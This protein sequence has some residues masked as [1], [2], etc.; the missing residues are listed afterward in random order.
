MA[1]PAELIISGA[2]IHTFGTGDETVE[3]IGIADGIVVSAGPLEPIE[4]DARPEAEHLVV[5]A[6]AILPG[7]CDTHMHF[8]KI[9]AE[10]HMLQLEDARSVDEILELLEDAAQQA[11][12]GEWIQS[13]G[14]DNAWHENRLTDNRLPTRTELDGVAPDHPVF[15]YRGWDAAVLNSRAVDALGEALAADPGWDDETGHLFS[16]LAR[17]L[18]E[19]LPAPANRFDVLESASRKLLGL[20]I[21][22]L[23]DPGLPACFDDTWHL[24]AQCKTEARVRQRLYLMDRLDHRKQFAAELE[25]VE[26][27]TTPRDLD[28][29]GLH[30]WGLKLLL[31]GEFD[32]AWM[33][34][35][36]PQRGTPTKR[37]TPDEIETALRFCAER[38]WPICFHVMG[39]GAVD[40]VISSVRTLG[41][42]STFQPHQVT[43]AHAFLPS[44]QNIC[45]CAELAI[46]ISVQPLLAFV[47]EK[48]M[49]EAWGEI[50]HRAN[51]YR[52]MLDL[53]AAIA[54]GSDV[55]PCEPLRGAA[56]AVT[57]I[58]RLGARL[59]ADQAISPHEAISL[60]TGRAG[61][62]VQRPLLGTLEVGAP[63]DFTAWPLDPLEV[64]AEKWPA[65]RPSLTAIGGTVTWQNDKQETADP[66][67]ERSSAR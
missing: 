5:E 23:V 22:S 3:A 17:T 55:L 7:F 1:K 40:A 32:N 44:E 31:D 12:P 37:Y 38:G 4:R 58:S 33:G 14:D 60:F 48:E 56:V 28:T 6:A 54:G 67:R 50:A 46:G 51:P 49:L 61:A 8:E 27:S 36:E 34:E 53:G 29:P 43:L 65:L 41:G 30:G 10:L 16:Q 2:P 62:Y 64:T 20:G 39:G 35:G 25:R 26:Q 18:Q 21:T 57:R 42:A 52:S 24:Y 9:A 13:F 47:F 59:G 66:V 19:E 45:D 15:L 63:A 11:T